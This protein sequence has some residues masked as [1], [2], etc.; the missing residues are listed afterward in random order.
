MKPMKKRVPLRLFSLFLCVLLL[1]SFLAACNTAEIP[2]EEES[3]T[4]PANSTEKQTQA[5]SEAETESD[6]AEEPTQTEEPEKEPTPF[7]SDFY[8]GY[9]IA[10][11][12][13]DAPVPLSG[14]G[15]ELNTRISFQ[16]PGHRL[17]ATCVAVK[18]DESVALLYNLDL[19][20]L[21]GDL[22]ESVQAGIQKQT[23]IP[24]EN[25][26]INCSHS[27]SAPSYALADY[28]AISTWRTFFYTKMVN[29]ALDS[30]ADLE[31]AE[32]YTGSTHVENMNFV[33]RY[34]LKDGTYD[35]V[36]SVS[37]DVASH[38]TQADDELQIILFKR[39]SKQ[40]VL[41]VNWRAHPCMMGSTPIVSGD[42]ISEFRKQM[43]EQGYLFA[44]H[45]GAAGN[46]T[47]FSAIRDEYTHNHKANLR[48]YGEVLTN[49]V[50]ETI[51]KLKLTNTDML[52]ASAKTLTMQIDHTTDHL[53]SVAK[54]IYGLWC[55]TTNPDSQKRYQE[56]CKQYDIPSAY[57]ASA[58]VARYEMAQTQEITVYALSFGDIA[59]A[60]APFEI[61]Q[62]TGIFIKENAPYQM[63]FASGYTNGAYG[64][65]PASHAFP[66]H[67]YEVDTCKYVRGS[68]EII[69]DTLLELLDQQKLARENS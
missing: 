18:S 19:I 43:E 66:H 8:V 58:I 7:S 16:T 26:L 25:I 46:V 4:D 29:L 3:D 44:F 42:Y 38:E 33:R 11:I 23:G 68:A 40:P 20:G 57:A 28:P 31:K 9:A 41:M 24:R 22:L 50:M 61:F 48:W 54:E 67:G 63:T 21:S 10:D 6:T 60:T 52:Q 53:A 32:A 39:Q 55:D 27:H 14:Y 34:L 36:S 17:Y 59:F 56:L 15:N 13:P 30:V 49:A 69:A 45:Q 51:P 1:L 37:D 65:L 47:T 62:E 35:T 5:A 64:Y 2:P 12:S